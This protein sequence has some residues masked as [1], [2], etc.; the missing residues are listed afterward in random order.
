MHI[1]KE[2]TARPAD[3]DLRDS[4]PAGCVSTRVG[5]KSLP[6]LLNVLCKLPHNLHGAEFSRRHG[7][8][9]H[10]PRTL[11]P[12]NPAAGPDNVRVRAG[13]QQPCLFPRL[14]E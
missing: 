1:S 6:L 4:E 13:S 14:E 9:I 3:S 10:R 12:K 11:G 5:E 8:K 2:K 7:R